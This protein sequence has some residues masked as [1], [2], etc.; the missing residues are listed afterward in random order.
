MTR[1]AFEQ[2]EILFGED[3]TPG[4]VAVESVSSNTMRLFLRQSGQLAQRDE[5]FTPF[6]LIEEARLLQDFKEPYRVEP[7]GKVL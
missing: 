4:I 6:M 7:L 2:N 5:I 1:F 3:P